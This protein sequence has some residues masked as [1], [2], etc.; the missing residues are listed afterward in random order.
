[1]Y[2]IVIM[3]AAAVVALPAFF[4]EY[5]TTAEGIVDHEMCGKQ[6]IAYVHLLSWFQ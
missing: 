3:Q 6:E 4:I 5:Y 1:M 2:V